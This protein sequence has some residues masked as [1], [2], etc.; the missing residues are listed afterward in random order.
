LD[1]SLTGL[2]QQV[3]SEDVEGEPPWW[4]VT[5]LVNPAQA[6]YKRLHPEVERSSEVQARLDYG[7][8]KGREADQW[9]RSLP[10]FVGA[11]G[12][13]D[14]AFGG[15]PGI[16]G[17]IDFRLGDSIVELKT[18]RYHMDTAAD[19]ITNSPQDLEQLSIYALITRREDGHHY[20]VFYNE[21]VAGRFRVFSVK[22]LRAPAL[23]QHFKARLAALNRSL[24]TR[25]PSTLGKCRYF[26]RGCEFTEVGLCS[27]SELSNIDT[28]E[29]ATSVRLDRDTALEERL[30]SASGPQALAADGK[31]GL[32]DLF[33]P[34]RAFGKLSGQVVDSFHGGEDYALRR[35][36]ERRLADSDVCA[37]RFNLQ[38]PIAGQPDPYVLKGRGLAIKFTETS[39][40][41]VTEVVTPLLVRVVRK[42]TSLDPKSLPGA[43]L[44]QLGALCA[45]RGSR[46]G[47][48]LANFPDRGGA[49]QC[50]RVRFDA[51][52]EMLRRLGRQA[53][54][55]FEGVER[56]SG[57][58]L[59]PCPDWIQ[60]DC[61]GGCPCD[62]PSDA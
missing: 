44:A 28:A 39:R 26:S 20:L 42:R 5:S 4:G 23:R 51:P 6:H 22:L 56:K 1:E 14:G 8:R 12:S 43:Y 9:F 34:R 62:R 11:E 19:V 49:V 24:E 53:R 52:E 21:G 30:R 35:D 60:E 32:W 29:L 40:A 13:V 17:R 38:I 2:L 7:R 25:N 36:I 50:F 27:C 3:L 54:A 33:V 16:R 37:Y 59:T 57:D 15:I 46:V 61:S 31:L 48:L 55:I 10:E 47:A 45:I 58:R 41:G 18:T